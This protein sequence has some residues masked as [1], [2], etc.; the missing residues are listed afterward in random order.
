MEF[1]AETYQNEYLPE[2]ATAVDAIVTVT[3]T[4]GGPVVPTGRTATERAV[5]VVLD[6]SG[7]M[8]A[9]RKIVAARNAAAA[10]ID[11]LRDGVL[12][13]IVAGTHRAAVRLP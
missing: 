2:G 8:R 11:S 10:A 4:G 7:S 9:R 12:F 1:R 6:M 13:G 3:A 5:V